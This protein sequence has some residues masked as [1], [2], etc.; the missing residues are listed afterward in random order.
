MANPYAFGDR[1]GVS[2]ELGQVLPKAIR[3]RAPAYV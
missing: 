2:F 3:Q 1:L